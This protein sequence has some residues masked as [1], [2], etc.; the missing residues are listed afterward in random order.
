MDSYS[1][2]LVTILVVHGGLLLGCHSEFDEEQRAA[3]IRGEHLPET[4]HGLVRKFVDGWVLC[5]RCKLPETRLEVGRTK[6][7][8]D[9]KA[10][11]ARR[12]CALRQAAHLDDDEHGAVVAR[13]AARAGPTGPLVARADRRAG[14]LRGWGDPG[15]L[16]EIWGRSGEI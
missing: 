10:C 4:V 6:V 8:F 7:T 15:G 9:C 12:G 3:V 1:G 14:H 11:G 13:R 2:F 16:G 5:G